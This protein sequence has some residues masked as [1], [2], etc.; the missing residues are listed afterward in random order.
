MDIIR[1]AK[2]IQRVYLKLSNSNPS[3]SENETIFRLL[4]NMNTAI[5]VGNLKIIEH[6]IDI[7]KRYQKSGA[8][9]LLS[10]VYEK[11]C[12][13]LRDN[14]QILIPLYISRI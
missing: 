6:Q 14:Q 1:E 9:E 8:C 10:K 13:F 4:L 12:N 3:L 2:L 5:L 7:F 11:E